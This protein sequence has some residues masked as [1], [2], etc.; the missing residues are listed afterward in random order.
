[1][2]FQNLKDLGWKK[3]MIELRG[4]IEMKQP[5]WI[6]NLLVAN[7][8]EDMIAEFTK[9]SEKLPNAF[10]YK[11][12]SWLLDNKDFNEDQLIEMKGVFKKAGLF[13]NLR[14]LAQANGYEN[15]K[16]ELMR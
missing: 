10:S 3:K 13:F 2:H 15:L 5:L 9:L 14:K 7:L 8:P 4:E 11:L 12:M 16:K 1:M 6:K